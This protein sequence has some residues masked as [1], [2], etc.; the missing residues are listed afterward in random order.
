MKNVDQQ[1]FV[2]KPKS[3]SSHDKAKLTKIGI[4][5][6]EMSNPEEFKFIKAGI[7]LDSFAV[8]KAALQALSFLPQRSG[9]VATSATLQRERFIHLMNE[10]MLDE[11]KTPKEN[12]A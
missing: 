11:D 9:N 3:I 2:C 4:V 1:I 7:E 12:A 8:F 10:A 5:V 6:I